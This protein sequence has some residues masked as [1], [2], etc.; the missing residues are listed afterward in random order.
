MYASRIL[1][2]CW[3]VAFLLVAAWPLTPGG[4]LNPAAVAYKLPGQIHWT[5]GLGGASQAIMQGD[6]SK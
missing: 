3:P 4:D 2:R 6:P 5:E 1:R